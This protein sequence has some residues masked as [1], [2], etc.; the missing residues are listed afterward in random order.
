[1]EPPVSDELAGLDRSTRF[2]PRFNDTVQPEVFD[3]RLLARLGVDSRGVSQSEAV[4]SMV[5]RLLYDDLPVGIDAFALQRFVVATRMDIQNVQRVASVYDS[6]FGTSD[7]DRTAEIAGA[8]AASASRFAGSRP[9][10]GPG[11]AVDAAAFRA[12]LSSSEAE[13]A[14]LA[15]VRSL[16]GLLAEMR[17]LGLSGREF[18]QARLRLLG[19]LASDAIGVRTLDEVLTP[20]TREALGG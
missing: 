11:G 20:P 13:A 19:P 5:G 6:V 12:F 17:T 3:L 18:A 8:L 15:H 2:P 16:E 9:G 14:T 10:R 7:Q 1:V 4:A